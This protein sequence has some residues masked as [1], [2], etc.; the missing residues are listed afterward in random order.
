HPT[1]ALYVD[2]ATLKSGKPHH[3]PGRN[4]LYRGEPVEVTDGSSTVP[5]ENTLM[6][7]YFPEST[8]RDVP[9]LCA[10]ATIEEIEAQGWSLNPGRYVGS[11][12]IDEDSVDLQVRL[13]E[14]AEEFA[15]L[16]ADVASMTSEVQL[17]LAALLGNG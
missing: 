1:V 13:E 14:L 11:S 10:L 6:S 17:N 5:T 8:Y 12:K 9:G 16:S 15:D 3:S 7:E 2:E 4:R